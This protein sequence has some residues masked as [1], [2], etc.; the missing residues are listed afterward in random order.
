MR[1]LPQEGAR[2][3]Q[4]RSLQLKACKI[5]GHGDDRIFGRYFKR[6]EGLMARPQ[7]NDVDYFPFYCKK[8]VS[9]DY[10]DETY[11][12]DGFA[13]WVKILREMATTNY[14]Y[15]NLSVKQKSMTFSSKCK[16]SEEMLFRIIGDLVELGEFDKELWYENKVVWSDKF[17]ESIEDAY[18][19]R[20]NNILKREEVI[21]LLVSLGVRKPISKGINSS[22]NPQSKEE[23]IKE[24][25]SKEE[26]ITPLV[27]ELEITGNDFTY[28]PMVPREATDLLDAICEYFD[29]K[30]IV[31]SKIYNSV[32]D[33]VATLTHRNELK[34][35]GIALTK[36]M[37][38]KARSKEAKHSVASWI[39][40]KQEHYN[41][42]QWAVIDWEKKLN[43]YEQQTIKGTNR[44]T[45]AK[46]S[47][48]TYRDG[49]LAGGS[50]TGGGTS[51]P[52]PGKKVE[53]HPD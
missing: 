13:V 5:G 37:S 34:L 9:T 48:N 16:V 21:H 38:Y 39:G 45:S 19:K 31:S 49:L 2:R 35:A 33:F 12:N 51:G 26:K 42:G 43:S 27:V 24:E 32:D 6:K 46:V 15:L 23:K 40:T 52:I 11:G 7:R 4:E 44:T 14:H 50:N 36:Y 53:I 30:K 41:D 22:V 1:E 20:S 29:V 8:G 28:S 10:I 18:K 17:I 3:Q 25:D 47:G